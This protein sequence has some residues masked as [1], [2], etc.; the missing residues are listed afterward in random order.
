V[1]G[2]TASV[3]FSIPGGTHP[4]AYQIQAVYSGFASFGGSSDSSKALMISRATPAITWATPADIQ[5]GSALGSGQLNATADVVGTFAYTPPA[6]T[7]LPVSNSQFL[8][9]T[10]SPMNGVDY[11]FGNAFVFINVKPVPPST[12]AQLVV[13]RSLSR[14]SGTNEIVAIVTIAN[15]GGT[16]AANVTLT[17][18]KVGA[19]GTSTALP[20]SLGTLA[21]GGAVLT[22]VRFPGSA[23]L[24][25]TASTITL[26]G[27]YTGGSFNSTAR[28]T[29]P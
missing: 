10:F 21:A 4:G 20:Q 7:V 27:T 25:G 23:G 15:T 1:T 13:T 29:L 11:T 16:A 9:E 19:T 24:P 2:G 17:I 26:G 28:I 3:L 22:A 6:G 14:D 8:S 5:F 18:A 12:P